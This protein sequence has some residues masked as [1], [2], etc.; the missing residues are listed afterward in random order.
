MQDLVNAIVDLQQR[1]AYLE[2][3]DAIPLKARYMTDTAQTIPASAF[4]IVNFDTV[5][6]DP[7]SAVTTGASWKFIAPI[8]GY[9]QVDA[10]TEITFAGAI[11]SGKTFY[12]YIYIDGVAKAV[13]GHWHQLVGSVNSDAHMNGGDCIYLAKDSYLDIRVWHDMT[14]SGSLETDELENHVSISLTDRT[15]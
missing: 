4:T 2:T 7:V 1:I 5:D 13:I 9:Y 11:A 6:Y 3:K 14:T 15:L 8:G 12:M 10:F